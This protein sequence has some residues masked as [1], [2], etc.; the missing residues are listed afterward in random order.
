MQHFK[1][2]MHS[3]KFGVLV[4]NSIYGKAG[5]RPAIIHNLI[6]LFD[7]FRLSVASTTNCTK[8][9]LFPTKNIPIFWSVHWQP[10]GYIWHATKCNLVWAWAPSFLVGIERSISGTNN[11]GLGIGSVMY[12]VGRL[13]NTY[14][15]LLDLVQGTSLDWETFDQNSPM[16]FFLAPLILGDPFCLIA[17]PFVRHVIDSHRKT[18]RMVG[19]D[20]L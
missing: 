7:C 18:V 13:K 11:I 19:Q 12:E 6:A 20:T 17:T 9:I 5:H 15:A 2:E 16:R 14:I 1:K 4:I 3:H 8:S 10:F